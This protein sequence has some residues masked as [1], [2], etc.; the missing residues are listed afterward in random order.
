MTDV[1]SN[2][3]NTYKFKTD[4]DKERIIVTRLAY[5]DGFKLTYKDA[6]GQKHTRQVFNGQGGFASFISGT[7]ECTYTL[8]FS[9]PYLEIASLISGMGVIVY[10]SSLCAYLYLDLRKLKRESRE[11][12]VRFK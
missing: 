7:D 8:T 4:F 9:T 3:A 6:N 5:E 10:F 1:I 12:I 11:E 2:K